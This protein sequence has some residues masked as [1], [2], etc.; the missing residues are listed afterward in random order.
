MESEKDLGRKV[1]KVLV[2]PNNAYIEYC[3]VENLGGKIQ[4]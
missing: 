3:A 2:P 1:P 4:L